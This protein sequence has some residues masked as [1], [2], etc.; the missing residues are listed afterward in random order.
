[1]SSL[2][3]S[4]PVLGRRPR[5]EGVHAVGVRSGIGY[6]YQKVIDPDAHPAEAH[7]IAV[8]NG[9]VRA[10]EG[11]VRRLDALNR[12]G[13]ATSPARTGAKASK[14]ALLPPS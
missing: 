2:K 14:T 4:S 5:D 3:L 9:L 13:R 8:P 6:A 11:R 10:A 7:L 12:A 1:M